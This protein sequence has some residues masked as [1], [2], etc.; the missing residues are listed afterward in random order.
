KE[1]ENKQR[2][3]MISTQTEQSPSVI[4]HMRFLF[5][6]V[7][8]LHEYHFVDQNKTWTEAQQ[9]CRDKYTDL[10]TVSSMVD[11]DR[12]RKINSEN[13]HVWIGLF[14]QTGTNAISHWSLPGLQFNESQAKWNIGEPNGG[15]A[16]T[17]GAIKHITDEKWLDMPCMDKAHFLCYNGKK[18]NGSL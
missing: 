4:E 18:K 5:K 13:K 7:G 1:I 9:H 8:T 11:I 14:N 17:C 15:V 12:L 6:L 3:D 2:L 10:A 16:E